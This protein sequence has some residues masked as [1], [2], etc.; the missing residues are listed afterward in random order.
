MFF[1]RTL[2]FDKLNC[3]NEM[4]LYMNLKKRFDCVYNVLLSERLK[5][6]YEQTLYSVITFVY[7]FLVANNLGPEQFGK[8]SSLYVLLMLFVVLESSFVLQYYTVISAKVSNSV[9]RTL[10]PGF[11]VF[12]PI[13]LSIGFYV[14][15]NYDLFFSMMFMM[16]LIIRFYNE[17]NRRLLL[18]SSMAIEQMFLNVVILCVLVASFVFF[19]NIDLYGSFFILLMVSV[20]SFVYYFFLKKSRL[21]G[22]FRW[23]HVAVSIKMMFRYNGWMILVAL[24]AYMSNQLMPFI[25]SLL[26]S[27]KDAGYFMVVLNYLGVSQVIL[28]A[29]NVYYLKKLSVSLVN[30]SRA[31]A[32]SIANK[33]G[34]KMAVIMMIVLLPVVWFSDFI[35]ESLYGDNFDVEFISVVY[36]YLYF[37]VMAKYQGVANYHK[38]LMKTELVFGSS[39]TALIAVYVVVLFVADIYGYVGTAFAV[40][41]GSIVSLLSLKLLTYFDFRKS[42]YE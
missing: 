20:I 11:V 23:R 32:Y 1:L 12:L 14:Y 40:F 5:Y 34:N 30:K 8:F 4:S 28:Q 42:A 24:F 38:I 29:L 31:E 9:R 18:I 39:V 17:F 35:I 27:S 6:I 25:L 21:G 13:L 10:M 33:V 22:G 2:F 36:L 15:Y 41:G 19:E 37:V 7:V 3:T 16:F 26:S